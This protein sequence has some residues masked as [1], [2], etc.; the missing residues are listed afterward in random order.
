MLREKGPMDLGEKSKKIDFS[1][2]ASISPRL[3][4]CKFEMTA[5]SFAELAV[6]ISVLFRLSSELHRAIFTILKEVI[7][8][9]ESQ[10][11]PSSTPQK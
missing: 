3:S 6:P 9:F 10:A 4:N 2:L 8:H 1:V 11:S 7:L 5:I